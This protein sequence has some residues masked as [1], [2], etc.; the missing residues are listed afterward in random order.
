MIRR[1]EN[2]DLNQVMSIWLQVNME[3]HSF[4][5]ADYW[6]NNYEMVREM[7]PK[8]EVLVSEENGQIRGFIG[9]IDTYIAG[10]FVR[11]AEQSKGVGTG[12]LHTVMKSRDN[13]RLN[14]YKKNM[15]AVSF[16]QHY[17]FQIKNQEIDESTSEEEYMMEWHR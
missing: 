9:L 2:K 10:I 6:K 12:L 4:I 1:F 7:I 13:L 3:S 16:Y 15:R 5:E 8:A 17:G 14:V 11:A